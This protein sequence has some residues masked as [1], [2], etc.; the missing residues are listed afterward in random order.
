MARRPWPRTAGSSSKGPTSRSS[1]PTSGSRSTWAGWSRSTRSPRACSSV[2]SGSCCTGSSRPTRTRR[3]DI[4]PV[5]LR[6]R[7]DLLPAAAA[8]RT[9]HFP[10]RVS[11]VDAARRRFA[12]EDFFVLQVGLTLRRARQAQ[13]RGRSLAPPGALVERLRQ[14]LPFTLTAAQERVSARSAA[15]LAR[16][17]PMNRL[18]QGDVGSGKTVVAAAGAA[19]RGRGRLP[20]RAHGADRDPRRAALPDGPRAGSRRSGST[21]RA[22]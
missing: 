1:R 8:Y 7:R 11:D 18:L 21:R 6:Q 19:D 4:L 3:P 5:E 22:C 10:E 16:P 9:V 17:V 14:G 20:G 12:F 15:D 2:R 13:E